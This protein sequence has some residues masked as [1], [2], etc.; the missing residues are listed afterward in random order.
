MFATPPCCH[1]FDR[2]CSLLLKCTSSKTKSLCTPRSLALLTCQHFTFVRNCLYFFPTILHWR[3]FSLHY[4]ETK[5]HVCENAAWKLP[6]AWV[7]SPTVSD[8]PCVFV[9]RQPQHVEVE[10]INWVLQKHQTAFS[11][12]WTGVGCPAVFA[13]TTIGQTF[14][15]PLRTRGGNFRTR[16]IWRDGMKSV[17]LV[18]ILC[19]VRLPSFKTRNW[20]PTFPKRTWQKGSLFYVKLR[21][22]ST[23]PHS[24]LATKCIQ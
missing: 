18:S 17:N 5:M 12:P 11:L 6:L 9:P 4:F 19:S 3:G 21:S 13:S 24:S 16:N 7:I 14:L 10:W 8:V 15:I 22:K 20:T 23:S 1:Y 2:W